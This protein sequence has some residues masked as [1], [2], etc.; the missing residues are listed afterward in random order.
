MT[1]MDDSFI[2]LWKCFR[3]KKKKT[4]VLCFAFNI[5]YP[6]KKICNFKYIFFSF[7]IF[8]PLNLY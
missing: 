5:T 2:W 8:F 7:V 3:K 1:V 4:E 6:K